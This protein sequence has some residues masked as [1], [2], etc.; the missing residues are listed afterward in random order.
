MRYLSVFVYSVLLFLGPASGNDYVMQSGEK[1][2]EEGTATSESLKALN[3]LKNRNTI[4]ASGDID[5]FVSLAAMLA[6][7]QDYDRFNDKKAATVVGYV[8]G[9]RP[10]GRESCNCDASNSL[11]MDTHIVLSLSKDAKKSQTVVA[12]VTPRLRKR[13]KDKGVDWSTDK[14]RSEYV[15]KWVEITGWLMFDFVHAHEAENTAPGHSGNVRATCWEIHPLTSIKLS[16]A[17]EEAKNFQTTSFAALQSM[18]A[19][20]LRNTKAI[21]QLNKRN[22]GLLEKLSAKERKEIEAE[23][24]ELSKEPKP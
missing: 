18:H 13:M 7:G 11:D 20:H 22:A 2:P 10:G 8:L 6:P 4:P 19:Q 9:V 12:E 15:G 21:E 14:L 3:R 17:P 24:K 1:C 16:A 5:P 23:S